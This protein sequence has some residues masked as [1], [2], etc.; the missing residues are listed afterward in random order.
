MM[1]RCLILV[2]LFLSGAP[3]FAQGAGGRG[4]P[5]PTAKQAAPVDLTGYWV[6]VVVEDWKYRML[7]A[8]KG[9]Y[10]GLP[11]NAA[12]R[13]AADA[14]DPAKDPAAR[15]DC[16]NYGAVNIMR[17]PGRLHIT[18]QDDR[19]LKLE[20]D[21]GMQMRLLSFAT[22]PN[23]SGDWQGDSSA[24]WDTVPSGRG[25][26]PTGSLKVVT[27]R[28]KPGFLR[29]NGVPYSANTTLTEY[30]DRVEFPDGHLYLVISTTVEDPVNLTASYLTSVHF[31][32]QAD[33]AGWNP[34]SCR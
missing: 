32:K 21:A 4:G 16:R 17:Q 33:A 9:D 29:S 34:T 24:A 12:A 8:N 31:R 1:Y 25:P 3:M 7:P 23:R 2:L 15:E 14:W 22:A 11:L 20:T 18:W 30:F 5:P 13:K 26:V 10:S 19:T 6:S 27:T 28:L